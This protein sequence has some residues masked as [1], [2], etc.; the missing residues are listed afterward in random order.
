MAHEQ[1]DNIVEWPGHT[2]AE[3]AKEIFANYGITAAD[4]NTDDDSPS[5]TADGHT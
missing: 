5:H 4:A 2:D 1:S 3:V